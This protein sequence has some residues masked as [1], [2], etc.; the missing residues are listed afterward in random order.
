MPGLNRGDLAIAD[1]EI[2]QTVN[3]RGGVNDATYL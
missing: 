3:A 2:F 1:R